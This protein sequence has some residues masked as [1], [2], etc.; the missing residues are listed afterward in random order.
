MERPLAEQVMLFFAEW[1]RINRLGKIEIPLPLDS[2]GLVRTDQQIQFWRSQ[3]WLLYYRPPSTIASF[4]DLMDHLSG[5]TSWTAHE[6]EI[7]REASWEPTTDGY[8]F[9]AEVGHN[10][11]NLITEDR[12][13]EESS[14]RFLSLEEY[15]IVHFATDFPHPL[16]QDHAFWE[17]NEKPM[18][19][20]TRVN[21]RLVT[22]Y[23]GTR[24]ITPY[25][26]PAYPRVMKI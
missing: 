21:G 19:L 26:K 20:R 4:I 10:A 15:I 17:W 2:R 7:F 13:S 12:I 14:R 6:M 24:I 23:S 25:N 9:W 8:W 11:D 16:V 1:Y 22:A 3:N 5:T 18:W